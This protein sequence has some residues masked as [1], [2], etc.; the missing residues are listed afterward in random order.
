MTKQQSILYLHKHIKILRLLQLIFSK[1]SIAVARLGLGRLSKIQLLVQLQFCYVTITFKHV[2]I[3]VNVQF[4]SEF[5]G[6]INFKNFSECSVQFHIRMFSRISFK[7][8]SVAITF[9][10]MLTS[11]QNFSQ[12]LFFKFYFVNN[13]QALTS[14]SMIYYCQVQMEAT[15]DE[16]VEDGQ[17]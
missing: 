7:F 1:I 4:M 13:L 2:R 11:C 12:C 10:Y 17:V 5:D 6:T 3:V 8:C 16:P 9:K 14:I 15:M